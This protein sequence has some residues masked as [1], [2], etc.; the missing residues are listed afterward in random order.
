M[1][2]EKEILLHT[3]T[4]SQYNYTCIPSVGWTLLERRHLNLVMEGLSLNYS[5][6]SST[7]FSSS[8]SIESKTFSSD[9]FWKQYQRG[10]KR[11]SF[12]KLIKYVFLSKNKV[13]TCPSKLEEIQ[14]VQDFYNQLYQ[15]ESN[16]MK[17]ENKVCINEHYES[18]FV[19]S[20]ELPIVPTS[21]FLDLEALSSSLL[22]DNREMYWSYKLCWSSNANDSC[23]W[24]LDYKYIF[25]F[26]FMFFLL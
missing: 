4:Y 23:F 12:W 14:T 3:I 5:F 9:K 20:A 25:G 21:S 19:S 2:K 22:Y 17:D 7:S 15:R 6:N 10:Q 24:Y 8:S 18:V 11:L 1:V 26:T 16:Q 13:N